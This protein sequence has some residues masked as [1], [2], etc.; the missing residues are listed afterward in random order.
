MQ[1]DGLDVKIVRELLVDPEV[2]SSKLAKK[3]GIPLSTIQRRKRKLEESVLKKKYVLDTQSLGWRSAEIMMSIENGKTNHMAEELLQK[4]EN[5]MSTS[6]RIN[7]GANLA[8]CISYRSSDELHELMESI[9]RMPSVTNIQW[10]EIVR[11]VGD[12]NQRLA[13]L[14]FDGYAK[15]TEIT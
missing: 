11:E 6:T 4:F 1:L 9:R 8:A 7:S 3:F 10:T 14:I 15:I 13:H 12:E 5:V 2:T